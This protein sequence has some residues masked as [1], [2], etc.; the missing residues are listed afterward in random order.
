MTLLANI[1]V[2]NSVGGQTP[3]EKENTQI[4]YHPSPHSSKFE[5]MID[6]L[7]PTIF[8]DIIGKLGPLM[9]NFHYILRN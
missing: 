4:S 8:F 9:D 1:R 6:D 2:L 5:I 3:L 7:D